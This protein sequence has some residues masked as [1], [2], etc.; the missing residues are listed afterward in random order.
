MGIEEVVTAPRS[1]WQNAYVER[2]IGSIRRECLKLLQVT[3]PAHTCFGVQG[4]CAFTRRSNPAPTSMHAA[5]LTAVVMFSS[6]SPQDGHLM[7]QGNKLKFQ[8][9]AAAN[10]EFED[11][12]KGAENRHHD[13]DGT[14]GPRKSPVCLSLVEI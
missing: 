2:I 4:H 7:S 8:R 14:A 1:P 13:R 5:R 9:G 12:N 11:R 10:T 6:M 3:E